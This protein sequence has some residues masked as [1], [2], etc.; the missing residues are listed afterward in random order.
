LVA[1]ALDHLNDASR[2]GA[3]FGDGVS[4][5]KAPVPAV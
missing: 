2:A 1:S 4:L 3:E 5:Y